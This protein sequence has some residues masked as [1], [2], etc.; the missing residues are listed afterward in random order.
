MQANISSLEIRGLKTH[1]QEWGEPGQVKLFLLHGW[2]DCGASFKYMAEEL[3]KHFH[4]IAPD[5]RGF[6]NTEHPQEG[7]WFP[8]YF[9]DLEVIISH[10][11]PHGRINL[12]GHSMG[13]NIALMYAGIN[14]ERV[15]RVLSM[16]SLGL[17][18]SE[19]K[20][21]P[22]KYRRWMR[23]TLSGE[24]PKVYPNRE[25]LL[26][27]IYKGNPTLSPEMIEDLADLWGKPHGEQGAW[28]L[29]HDHRHRYANPVRYNF[30]D[31]VEV[32]KEI[33]AKVGLMMASESMH[34]KHFDVEGRLAEAKSVLRIADDNYFVVQ[35]SN[36]MMHLE[37]PEQTAKYLIQFFS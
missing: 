2:M 35:D 21:A 1:I 15:S 16:D 33:Q 13:G 4:V 30:D 7:Y 26:R 32:W 9:A 17:P 22:D 18:K 14:P 3:A 8:D 31:V 27:S 36:H 19:S 24:E 6:G 12:A 34:F 20:D 10:Y 25:M 23:E 28:M 29:K 5:L 11:V 37:K